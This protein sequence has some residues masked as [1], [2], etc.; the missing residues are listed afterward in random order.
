[1][2]TTRFEVAGCGLEKSQAHCRELE[3][4][5][6]M[7]TP[8]QG[9][10]VPV[11]IQICARNTSSSTPLPDRSKYLRSGFVRPS[12]SSRAVVLFA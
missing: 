5:G 6:A 9:G 7:S 12:G 11:S 10:W 3:G 2:E 4:E 1:M 8:G